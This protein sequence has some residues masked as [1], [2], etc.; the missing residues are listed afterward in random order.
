MKSSNHAFLVAEMQ[1]YRVNNAVCAQINLFVCSLHLINVK[2]IWQFDCLRC[3]YRE[4][5]CG[6]LIVRLRF[7]WNSNVFHWGY[8]KWRSIAILKWRNIKGPNFTIFFH[9]DSLFR[10]N[11]GTLF[12]I[13]SKQ[14]KYNV[15]K[16][17]QST[18]NYCWCTVARHKCTWLSLIDSYSGLVVPAIFSDSVQTFRVEVMYRLLVLGEENISSSL[19][20]SRDLRKCYFWW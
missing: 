4:L 16:Y 9:F 15:I 12:C 17:F 14:Q 2:Q 11:S 8:S 10:Y 5:R 6:I 3:P 7:V 19:V 18:I 1:F 13:F 20:L